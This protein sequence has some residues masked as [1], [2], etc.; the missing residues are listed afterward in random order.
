[1]VQVHLAVAQPSN[2]AHTVERDRDGDPVDPGS[3]CRLPAKAIQLP[4]GADERVLREFG[5]HIEVATH[6]VRQSMD[7]LRVRVVEHAPGVTVSAED[8]R[9]EFAL[10]QP[11]MVV[12]CQCWMGHRP[13]ELGHG[14]AGKRSGGV[15]TVAP[16]PPFSLRTAVR[17]Q[18]AGRID[19]ER[20]HRGGRVLLDNLEH[21]RLLHELPDLPRVHDGRG[22]AHAGEGGAHRR[23]EPRMGGIDHAEGARVGAAGG[24]D[25]ELHIRAALDVLRE[26]LGGIHRCRAV[27]E[28]SH[29]GVDLEH[30][31]G[32]PLP[33]LLDGHGV[34]H[35]ER[36]DGCAAQRRQ[37]PPGVERLP[38]VPGQGPDVGTG[39]AV[40]LHVQ[41]HDAPAVQT[42]V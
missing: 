26:Q 29:R 6:P 34:V 27:G 31:R 20:V 40:D 8:A 35:R 2:L 37:V 25:D 11:L 7:A 42:P 39:G 41:V 9:D 30:R 24:I 14:V 13:R 17:A 36:S 32:E 21:E 22:E 38:E 16:R 1:M 28:P 18:L 15:G 19:P 33:Q 4:E 5:R 3:K 12:H 10:V 23:G